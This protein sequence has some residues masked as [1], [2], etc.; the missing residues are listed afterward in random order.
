MF[1]TSIALPDIPFVHCAEIIKSALFLYGQPEP[2]RSRVQQAKQIVSAY[3]AGRFFRTES[4][5]GRVAQGETFG[6]RVKYFGNIRIFPCRLPRLLIAALGGKGGIGIIFNGM[7]GGFARQAGKP[8]IDILGYTG[9]LRLRR[10]LCLCRQRRE[11]PI[12]QIR[13]R[14][15]W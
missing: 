14:R 10:F 2:P 5:F 15:S 12:L 9:R 3:P 8:F 11:A 6:G 7:Q 1:P 4:V 13:W